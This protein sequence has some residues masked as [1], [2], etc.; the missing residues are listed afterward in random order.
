MTRDFNDCS[1]CDVLLVNLLGASK[2]SIGTVMEIA[3][4][5]QN[6]T[7]VVVV[8]EQEGNP[9]EHAMIREAIGFRVHTMGE[10]IAVVRTIL[11]LREW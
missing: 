4:A 5:Y 9:H 10:A 7:P 8:M 2:V 3:W 11:D 6:R 1:T